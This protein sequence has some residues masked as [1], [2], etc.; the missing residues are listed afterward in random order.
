MGFRLIK[1]SDY[2]DF[3]VYPK[4]NMYATIFFLDWKINCRNSNQ[5]IKIWSE[6][7]P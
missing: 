6:N 4:L 5:N 3:T 7:W 1:V 2:T